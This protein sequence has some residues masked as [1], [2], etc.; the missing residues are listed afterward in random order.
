LKKVNDLFYSKDRTVQLKNGPASFKIWTGP[1][2]SKTIRHH[3]ATI[4]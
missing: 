4:K 1:I 3:K 2:R